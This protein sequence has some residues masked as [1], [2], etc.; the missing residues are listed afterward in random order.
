MGWIDGEVLM[1]TRKSF[2]CAPLDGKTIFIALV[3][4]Q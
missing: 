3:S 4:Y 1:D 2:V